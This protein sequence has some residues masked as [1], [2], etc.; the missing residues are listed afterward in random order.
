VTAVD[1]P[2][3]LAGRTERIGVRYAVPMF[4]PARNYR[5]PAP[6]S[7][8]ASWKRVLGEAATLGV[9]QV[10]FSG[11]EPLVRATSPSS[12]AMRPKSGSTVT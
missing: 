5:A 12:C 4:E 1:P 11:G 9:L 6:N 8:R 10:H 3:A 7:T 2:L